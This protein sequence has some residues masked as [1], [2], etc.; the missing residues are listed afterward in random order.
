L[1]PLALDQFSSGANALLAVC[2]HLSA[3]SGFPCILPLYTDRQN[4]GP[5]FSGGF[6]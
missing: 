3:K 4:T 6:L 2:K 5:T 1:M